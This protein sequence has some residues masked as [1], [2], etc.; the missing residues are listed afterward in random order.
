MNAR[1]VVRLTGTDLWLKVSRVYGHGLSHEDS[2]TWVLSPLEASRWET[3]KGAA[4][5]AEKGVPVGHFEIFRLLPSTEPVGTKAV[6][7]EEEVKVTKVGPTC[8]TLC[9]DKRNAWCRF[10]NCGE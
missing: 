7:Y 10:W 2:F 9:G 6:Y 4:K 3:I 8:T 1:Y 5:A